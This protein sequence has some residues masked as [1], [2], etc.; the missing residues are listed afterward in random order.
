MHP[1]PA[2]AASLSC[3]VPFTSAHLEVPALDVEHVDE[4]LHAAENVVPLAGEVVLVER[5]LPA[6]VPQVEDQVAEETHV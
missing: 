3:D 2:A 4:E 1:F 6:A 5:V